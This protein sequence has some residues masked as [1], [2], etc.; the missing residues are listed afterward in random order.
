MEKTASDA[1]HQ[2]ATDMRA[3]IA[4][5]EELLKVTA[6]EAG[7]RVKATRARIEEKLQAARARLAEIDVVGQAKD[8]ARHTDT[9]VHEHPW[10]AVGIA[11]VAG[12]LV[13]ILVSRR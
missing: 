13:G 5:A 8:A 2:L 9:Y 7:E 12:L 10:G 1:R 4:D 11:A 6:G 3:V